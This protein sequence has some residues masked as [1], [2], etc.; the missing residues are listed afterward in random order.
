MKVL[1]NI[2]LYKCEYCGKKYQR[3]T[4]GERHERYCYLNPRND[5][6]C[7]KYCEYL[8]FYRGDTEGRPRKIYKCTA[9]GIDM[10][11]YTA[12]RKKLNVDGL[13][14]M[15]LQCEFYLKKYK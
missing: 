9:K 7:F 3:R 8:D 5:H 15:P 6:P 2:T 11:C 1:H 12:E 13:Q 4:F 10:F 14:R